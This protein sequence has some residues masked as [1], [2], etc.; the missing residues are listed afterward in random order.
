MT[1]VLIGHLYIFNFRNMKKL[2]LKCSIYFLITLIILEILVRIFHLAKDNPNRYLDEYNVEKWKPNQTGYS[3]TGNRNQNFSAYNINNSG[4]NSYREFEPTKDKFEIALV[5][6][7]FI[8]GFHQNYYHSIGKKIEETLPTIEVY[9]YGYAGYDYADQ[10]H[11]I[12]QYKQTF[13]LIDKV[14]IYINF[15]DDLTR[16]TY[17]VIH[18]RLNLEKGFSKHLKKAN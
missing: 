3:V 16:G 13:N 12:D 14:I 2:I 6:D 8:Q 10:I 18:D 9:E 11:L 7:S 1:M 5:G 15:E 4:Y 17:K